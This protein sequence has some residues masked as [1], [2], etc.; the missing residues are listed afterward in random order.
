MILGRLYRLLLNL[1]PNDFESEYRD[2]AAEAFALLLERSE[3]RRS[4]A[5]VILLSFGR[6]PMAVIDDWVRFVRESAR[7][8]HSPR[9]PT[10][11][12]LPHHHLFQ[13][14]RSL[15]KVPAFTFSA[16]TLVAIGVGAV[17]TIFTLVD[18]ILLRPLPYPAAE[19]L[20]TVTQGSHSGPLFS[21]MQGLTTVEEWGA[22]YSNHLTL[23]GSGTPLQ[24]TGGYVSEDFLSLLGATSVRGRLLEAEDYLSN[25]GV[26]ISAALWQRIWDSDPELVGRTIQLDGASAVVLGVVGPDFSPPEAIVGRAPVD[27]WR[28]IDWSDPGMASHEQWRLEVV[29]RLRAGAAPEDADAEVASLMDRMAG[30]HDNYVRDDGSPRSVPVVTLADEMVREVR[31]GLG[32]LMGAVALLLLV[33]CANVAHLF[34]ARGMGRHREMAIRKALGAGTPTL[35]GQLMTESLVI[36]LLGGAVGLVLAILG[37]EVFLTLN[38]EALPREAA[39]GVDLRILAFAAGT[40][41]LTALFFGLLPALKA[42]GKDV[43][44]ELRGESRSSTN[45][46]GVRVM[47]SGLMV[48]EVALSLVLVASAALLFRSFVAVQGQDPGFELTSIWTLPLTPTETETPDEYRTAMNEVRQALAEVPGVRSATYGLTLPLE[49]TGGGRCCWMRTVNTIDESAEIN[50]TVFHPVSLDFFETLSI[51]ILY[52]RSWSTSEANTN[53]WPAVITRQTATELFGGAERALNQ[54]ISS[55][56]AALLVVGVAADTRHYGLDAEL[57]PAAYIPIEKMPFPID[58]AHMAVRVDGTPN[59]GLAQQLREAV[60]RAAPGLPVPTVRTMDEWN[61]IGTAG[62]RFDSALFASFGVLALLLAAGGLYGTLLYVAGQRRRELAIRLA[63]GASR[64]TIERWMLRGGAAVAVVGVIIGLFGA[65][66]AARFLESRLWGVERTDPVALFGAAGVL[67]LVAAF[68]SWLPARRAG[69]TDPL[70]AL[71]AE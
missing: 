2:E 57:T 20:V 31:G 17:T 13:T 37:L 36:G 40:S 6:L 14:L 30:V 42:V 4:A 32:L 68:A 34:L 62:R 56:G 27:L 61:E 64:Q 53:P 70:E 58:M 60:W 3:G 15:G 12:L 71:R 38:P 51:P 1:F 10:M 46:P 7:R 48:A 45:G 35:V 63:L 18:H 26:V 54:Q 65:W 59:A 22:A 28:T 9:S 41:L 52:G 50:S 24:L 11:A 39:V 33:A 44:R 29:G 55:G 16:I 25:E 67:L 43:D 21:E 49:W 19:R 5:R 47:R 8:P 23:T 69:R 66:G